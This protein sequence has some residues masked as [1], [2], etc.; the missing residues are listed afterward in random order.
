MLNKKMFYLGLSDCTDI[1]AV[2]AVYS[3]VARAWVTSSL[4]LNQP[5]RG[6]CHSVV[7]KI[8]VHLPGVQYTNIHAEQRKFTAYLH[9]YGRLSQDS[10]PHSQINSY[11]Y[12]KH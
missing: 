11:L 10:T 7:P 1:A 8:G 6:A 5:C 4:K 9:K 2:V 3:V 12:I